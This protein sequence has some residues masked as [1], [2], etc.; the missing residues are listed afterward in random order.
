MFEILEDDQG[1]LWMSCS[2]GISRVRKQ[3]LNALE[4]GELQTVA[5]SAYGKADGLETTQCNGTAK[6]AAWKTRDGRLWFATSKG[7]VSVDPATLKVSSTPPPRVHRARCLPDK[8]PSRGSRGPWGA[9]TLASA[10]AA[11]DPLAIAPGRGE[12]EFHYTALDFQAPEEMP[13]QA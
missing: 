1:W 8:K 7:V 9:G 3:D 11:T 10:P 6:P 5:S 13:L 2:K 12:L 4:A